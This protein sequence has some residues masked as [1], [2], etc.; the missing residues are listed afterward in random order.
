MEILI[1]SRRKIPG[2]RSQKIKRNLKRVLEDL[3]YPD[4]EL[5]VFFTDDKHISELNSRYLAR[6]GPTN[7]LAFPM[8]AGPPPH[9]E[10]GMLGD[11]VISVD[12]AIHESK[13]LGEP[14][15]ETIYRLLIHGIL[16][17]LD[18]DHERS[19]EDARRM[20]KEQR[21]LLDSIQ[22]G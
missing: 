19:P 20:E 13:G 5:S 17:L 21:K 6:N 2:I 4:S 1:R 3:A 7:V 22:R 12:R 11:I 10:T 8:W 18:Y 16:H 15:E 14:L 9:V